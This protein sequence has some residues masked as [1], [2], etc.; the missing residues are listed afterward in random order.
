MVSSL[1]LCKIQRDIVVVSTA[2]VLGIQQRIRQFLS[3]PWRS[4]T[5]GLAILLRSSRLTD[6]PSLNNVEVHPDSLCAFQLLQNFCFSECIKKE[7]TAMALAVVFMYSKYRASVKDGQE[8][9]FLVELGSGRLEM[10]PFS[11]A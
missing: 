10:D 5:G 9:R 6:S 1:G 8:G 7:S 4:Y 2:H 3:L 11:R